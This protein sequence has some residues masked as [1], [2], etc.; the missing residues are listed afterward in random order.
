M[1]TKVRNTV[2]AIMIPPEKSISLRIKR[3]PVA[4]VIT[5]RTSMTLV[6][7]YTIIAISF[8]SFSTLILTF[9]VIIAKTKAA[10]WIESM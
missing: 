4:K 8:E 7:V 9:R 2:V 1:K 5:P 6:D 3:L 10:T